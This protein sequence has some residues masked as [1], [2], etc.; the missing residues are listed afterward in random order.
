MIRG[1]IEIS[2]EIIYWQ[3][4]VVDDSTFA[5]EITCANLDNFRIRTCQEEV[6][7]YACQRSIQT[8]PTV[9]YFVLD[10]LLFRTKPNDVVDTS[11]RFYAE[12]AQTLRTSVIVEVKA[13]NLCDYASRIIF[14]PTLDHYE[15]VDMIIHS[16]EC[17]TFSV[18]DT[19]RKILL[20]QRSE[21]GANGTRVRRLSGYE[22]LVVVTYYEERAVLL[23][24]FETIDRL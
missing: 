13:H 21:L 11:Q 3:G 10:D 4:E 9:A 22:V 2:T 20:V 5:D 1:F 6:P 12:H 17:D 15:V 14:R 24:I 18:P 8:K 16:A 7:L 19:L 23:I